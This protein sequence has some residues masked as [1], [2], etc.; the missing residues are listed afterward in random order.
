[1]TSAR[2]MF[3]YFVRNILGTTYQEI[4][5]TYNYDHATIIYSIKTVENLLSYDKEY[6]QLLKTIEFSFK[7]VITEED[8]VKIESAK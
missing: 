8:I 3:F 7:Q 2:Q 1:M 5:K 6:K 4:G